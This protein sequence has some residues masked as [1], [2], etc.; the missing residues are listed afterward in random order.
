MLGVLTLF[1]NAYASENIIKVSR[2]KAKIE[3]SVTVTNSVT[4]EELEKHFSKYPNGK[5]K[6][7]GEFFIEMEKKHGISA[8]F[9]AA[10]ATQESG[11]GTKCANTNNFFGVRAK[12]GWK[13][14]ESTEHGIE[15]QF[16]MIK[17]VYVANGRTTVHSIGKRYCAGGKWASKVSSIM[18]SI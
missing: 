8:R 5:L 11:C 1:S 12:K 14:F 10:I 18:N 7:Y 6:G 13:K 4:A 16:A 15:E 3:K 2:N 9:I 17:R